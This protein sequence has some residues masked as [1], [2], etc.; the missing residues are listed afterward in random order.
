M[1]TR[2]LTAYGLMALM[3]LAAAAIAFHLWYN[4]RRKTDGRRRTRDHAAYEER[5]AA[6]REVE[7]KQ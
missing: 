4:S 2:L 7:D 3:L 6:Q 5:M 1:T